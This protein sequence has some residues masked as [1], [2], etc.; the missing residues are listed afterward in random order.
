MHGMIAAHRGG[1]LINRLL[2]LTAVEVA[3]AVTVH[4]RDVTR[5][6]VP[7]GLR[8]R[9]QAH[10][11]INICRNENIHTYI[12]TYTYLLSLSNPLTLCKHIY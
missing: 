7:H 5:R 8:I 4:A 10:I 9:V 12:H 2:R 3:G 6:R 1:M 11:F